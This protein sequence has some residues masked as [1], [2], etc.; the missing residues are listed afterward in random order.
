MVTRPREPTGSCPWHS[1]ILIGSGP[2]T[3]HLQNDD[4]TKVQLDTGGAN[5]MRN[6][7]YW[8]VTTTDGTKYYFGANHGWSSRTVIASGA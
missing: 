1:G 2:G 3:W 6:G 5:G 8:V 7:E 4:G